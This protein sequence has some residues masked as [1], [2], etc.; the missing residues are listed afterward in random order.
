M[1]KREKSE[2]LFINGVG[3]ILSLS[4]EEATKLLKEVLEGT[5]EEAN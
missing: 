1:T 2:L 3:R 5:K 4:E